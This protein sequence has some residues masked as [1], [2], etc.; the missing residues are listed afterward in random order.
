MTEE[1]GVAWAYG[2]DKIFFQKPGQPGVKSSL[3]L[4]CEFQQGSGMALCQNFVNF[5]FE[6]I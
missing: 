1:G 4:L 2:C 5:K 3:L 6:G